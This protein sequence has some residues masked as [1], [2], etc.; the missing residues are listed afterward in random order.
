MSIINEPAWRK[1]GENH[2]PSRW[3]ALLAPVLILV[4]PAL[5]FHFMLPFTDT[6]ISPSR[7]FSRYYL[8]QQMENLVSVKFGSFPMYIPAVSGS[9]FFCLTGGYGQLFLPLPYLASLLPGYWT[10]Y[11]YDWV[12]LLNMLTIS[13]A[14]LAL[15]AFLHRL[16]LNRC[17]SLLFSMATVYTPRIL[18]SFGYGVGIAAWTGHIFLCAAMGFYFLK[19]SRVK[20]PLLMVAAAYWLINSGHPAEVYFCML[21]AWVFLLLLPALAAVVD[22]R[23]GRSGR[24]TFRFWLACA[25]CCGLAFLL[26]AAYIVPLYFDVIRHMDFADMSF[27]QAVTTTDTFSGLVYNFLLP[28]RSGLFGCFAGTSLYL[29]VVLLPLLRLFRISITRTVWMIWIAIIVVFFYMAGESTPIFSTLWHWL[30]FASN[31]RNPAR[32]SLMMPGIFLLAL[33]WLFQTR[34]ATAV[35]IRGRRWAIPARSMLAAA[36]LL[37]LAAGLGIMAALSPELSAYARLNTLFIPAWIEPLVIFTA[38][39]TVAG[40]AVHGLT[41]RYRRPVELF[42]CVIVLLHL[43]LLMRYT[44][45]PFHQ[46]HEN[47]TLTLAR[48]IAQKQK[49]LKVV[50]E[51]LFLFE[52]ASHQAER[53]QYRNYFVEPHLGQVFRKY[54]QAANI[55]EAYRILNRDRKQDEV[56]LQDV[57]VKAYPLAENP[58]CRGRP[59][60]VRLEYS[61]YNRLIFSVEACQRSFFVLSY[62][63]PEKKWRARVN[64][65]QAVIYPANGI[66]QAVSIPAGQST[67]EFRYWSGT[68]F[69]GMLISCLTL[70]LLGIMAGKRLRRRPAAGLLTA[71]VFLCLAAGLFAA[72]FHSLYTGRSFGME[73]TWQT[74][75]Q[76]ELSNQAFGKP[77]EIS[78]YSKVHSPYLHSRRGV[79]GD[80]SFYSCMVT[81]YHPNPWFQVDLKKVTPIGSIRLTASLRGYEEDKMILYFYE[82]VAAAG[83]DGIFVFRK[84][85]VLFNKLPLLV[86]LSRDGK[87]WQYAEVDGL[88]ADVPRTI[89]LAEPAAAR[90]VRIIAAGTCRLC[91]NEVEVYPPAR[92]GSNGEEPVSPG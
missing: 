87:N 28:I 35:T 34:A 78:A 60:R 58:Q 32:A 45:F 42:L 54:R 41:I 51:H 77:T 2:L 88:T 30:P 43:V 13:L 59:D 27:A 68:A 18:V 82:N 11:A 89:R 92:R 7:D 40:M 9:D 25:G 63:D 26:S 21:G 74:P 39:L 15:Y 1:P 90:Y 50:P 56:V 80:R 79:D 6:P 84:V 23:Q 70:A 36:A 20:G 81:G 67:V 49:T 19:P 53:R 31:T 85:P 29:A 72:W 69:T 75:S 61:T 46:K 4:L 83:I 14:H 17:L 5:L 66:S 37:V 3:R 55:E 44:A 76:K 65:E 62:P 33:I 12:L 48:L 47:D 73:Y 22:P 57:P 71:A 86:A 52:A 10:G 16:G 64:G 38:F 24:E 91:L 8:W